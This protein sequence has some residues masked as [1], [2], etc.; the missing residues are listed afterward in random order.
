MWQPRGNFSLELEADRR[1]TC[2]SCTRQEF[3]PNGREDSRTIVKDW[4]SLL[5]Q[6]EAKHDHTNGVRIGEVRKPGQIG[7]SQTQE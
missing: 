1:I 6:E 2:Q 5:P 7:K 3:G 4:L